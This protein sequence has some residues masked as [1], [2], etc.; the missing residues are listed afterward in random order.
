MKGNGLK[1]A[2]LTATLAFVFSAPGSGADF[3]DTLYSKGGLQAKVGYCMDCHGFSARGYQGYFT[4]PRLAGQQPE[5]LENQLRAFVERRRG[6]TIDLN[7]AR[8]HGGLDP[9]MRRALAT[10]FLNVNARPFGSGPKHLM[11]EGRKIYEE[12]TPETNV[13]ACA[14]CHGPVAEGEAT[15]PRLAGQLYPYTVKQ[16]AEWNRERGQNSANDT[17]AIMAPIA[18]SL[19]KSQI[20]AVAAYLSSLQ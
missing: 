4:M 2:L 6:N 19:T 12:G 18:H 3:A 9:A 1:L 7:I 16:L 14:A 8:V 13:P 15:I 10:H 17:S 11:A 5:Y 20:A